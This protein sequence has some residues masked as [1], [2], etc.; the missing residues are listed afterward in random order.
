MLKDRE[1]HR[2][3][4]AEIPNGHTLVLGD[5]GY[6]KTFYC[7]QRLT[8][9]LAMGGNAL[10]I[11]Y[12]NSYSK[13][14]LEKHQVGVQVRVMNPCEED[15]DFAVPADPARAVDLITKAI[16][17][18]IGIRSYVQ[19]AH[20]RDCCRQVLAADD[21]F[22]FPKLIAV[23]E[24]KLWEAKVT[25]G[26]SDTGKDLEKLLTRISKMQMLDKFFLRVGPEDH[27][28]EGVTILQLSD[29]PREYQNEVVSLC[30]NLLWEDTRSRKGNPRYRT[31][32]LDEI[33]NLDLK[34]GS[35]LYSFLREGRKFGVRLI[36]STQHIQDY[37]TAERETLM[38]AGTLMFFRPT[39]KGGKR[40]EAIL[41]Q[42]CEGD[43]CKLILTLE[44]GQAILY[45]NYYLND[46]KYVSSRPLIVNVTA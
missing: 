41:S 10:V 43:W 26:E 44:I 36:L 23:L 46:N 31:I 4:L 3:R 40:I 17:S 14:E 15:V 38:Q 12:S 7:T 45:G 21:R 35:T 34:K 28:Q 13:E 33:Q 32:L 19:K 5:S 18:A 42:V 2:V 30:M 25:P 1:G 24:E 39:V 22:S 6:G 8:E 16:E 27:I 11:D 37:N 9:V 29:I 20:L